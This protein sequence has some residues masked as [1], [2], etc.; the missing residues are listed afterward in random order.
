MVKGF[1]KRSVRKYKT[2][3]IQAKIFT[4]SVNLL[5]SNCHD[6]SKMILPI[7]MYQSVYSVFCKTEN[8]QN[9]PRK[10][11]LSSIWIIGASRRRGSAYVDQETQGPRPRAYRRAHDPIA[12]LGN[13]RAPPKKGEA[14]PTPWH[15][16]PQPLAMAAETLRSTQSCCA[17]DLP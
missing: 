1:A 16:A 8:C 6:S 15:C 12:K 7:C 17:A 9:S 11:R 10:L 13:G 14:R 3:I 2:L 4:D 5:P